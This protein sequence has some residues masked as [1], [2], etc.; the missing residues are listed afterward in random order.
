MIGMKNV[1][2]KVRVILVGMLLIGFVLVAFVLSGKLQYYI[3]SFRAKTQKQVELS[4][5]KAVINKH[6]VNWNELVSKRGG[7]S[8]Q[9]P[10]DW[11]LVVETDEELKG[12]DF[13]G[14]KQLVEGIDFAERYIR[15]AGNHRLGHITV[16]KTNFANLNEYIQIINEKNKMIAEGVNDARKMGNEYSSSFPSQIEFVTIGGVPAIK[17]TPRYNS[18][19]GAIFSSILNKYVVIN[20]SKLYEFSFK[21]TGAELNDFEKNE[22]TFQY[23]LSTVKFSDEDGFEELIDFVDKDKGLSLSHSPKVEVA[24]SSGS[25][26]RMIIIRS[27]RATMYI[28]D[29]GAFAPN[30]VTSLCKN[31]GVNKSISESGEI[32]KQNYD[33]IINDTTVSGELDVFYGTRSVSCVPFEYSK[34][35]LYFDYLKLDSKNKEVFEK[36]LSTLVI[37]QIDNYD[38][39][40]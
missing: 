23:I 33:F 5:D 18:R 22:V 27:G 32:V 20:N 14:D 8:L 6:S 15:N 38:V 9:Y 2:K 17:I 7:F 36:I 24:V 40:M 26:P 19:G 34:F 37:Y 35:D 25:L 10:D 16:S 30:D 4:S 21:G 31:K 39:E 13:D 3:D 1:S 12:D 29:K 28:V 11:P